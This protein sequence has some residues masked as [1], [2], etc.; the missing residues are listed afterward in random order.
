[1]PQQQMYAPIVY[2]YNTPPIMPVMQPQPWDQTILN[3]VGPDPYGFNQG[4]YQLGF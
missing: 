2:D 4:G 1:M 3:P